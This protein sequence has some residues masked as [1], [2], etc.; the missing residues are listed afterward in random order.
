MTRSTLLLLMMACLSPGTLAAETRVRS[1]EHSNF[2]RLVF[3]LPAAVGGWT[4]S[5]TDDGYEIAIAPPPVSLETSEVFSFIPR[6]RVRDIGLRNGRV[7]IGSD[8]DCHLS[9]FQARP[10]VIAVDV[11]DGP[12]PVDTSQT[13]A[14]TH[15]ETL[16]HRTL[17]HRML[18]PL[19]GTGILSDTSVPSLVKFVPPTLPPV[20]V[21][22]STLAGAV[23]RA[24]SG[25]I[26]NPSDQAVHLDSPGIE[27][28]SALDRAGSDTARRA[29]S[30]LCDSVASLERLPSIS[31]FD[32]WAKIEAAK[33]ADEAPS[34]RAMAYFSLGFGAEAAAAFAQSD[35]PVDTAILLTQLAHSV[36]QPLRPAS[37]TILSVRDCDGVP[38]L[39][40]MLATTLDADISEDRGRD[41]VATL[42]RLPSPLRAHLAPRLEARLAAAGLSDLALSARFTLQR[43]LDTQSTPNAVN[44]EHAG[45]PGLA[46]HPPGATGLPETLF[47]QPQISGDVLDAIAAGRF[48]REDRIL[49]DAWIQEAPSVSEADAATR[50]YVSALNSAG[51]PLVALSHLD[52]RIGRRGAMRPAIEDAV[53]ETL[54]TAARDLAP[55]RLILLEARLAERPWYASVPQK[56]RNILAGRVA[57]VRS[58]L[59]GQPART[60]DGPATWLETTATTPAETDA[61]PNAA[62]AGIDTASISA[63]GRSAEAAIASAAES[64]AQSVRLRTEAADLTTAWARNTP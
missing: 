27:T 33:E 8:C 13:T 19:I 39:I 42:S 56:T 47:F 28:R 53:A 31:Q 57:M 6:T 59:L 35:L 48:A 1:G 5:R 32:A 7:W 45:Q 10:N 63:R 62:V 2:T 55:G 46:S 60:A 16:A 37:R 12:G 41:Y 61:L 36:D 50:L 21:D 30:Q 25:G 22:P 23:A 51:R 54:E 14:A 11:R 3:Y 52:A 15:P 29:R 43:T 34:A 49:I 64:I 40:G 38:G 20:S 9:V 58:E 17:A 24:T 26:L 18:P 4:T 44:G